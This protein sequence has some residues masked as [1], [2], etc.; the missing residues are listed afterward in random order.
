M[1]S[2]DE[3]AAVRSIGVILIQMFVSVTIET[4]VLGMCI[5]SSSAENKPQRHCSR[6]FYARFQ[7]KPVAHV[8]YSLILIF[9]GS[10]KALCCYRHRSPRTK[11]S[12]AICAAVLVMFV[13]SVVLWIIDIHNTV[14]QIKLT[15]LSSPADTWVDRSSAATNDILRWASI[16]DVLYSYMVRYLTSHIANNENII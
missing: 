16:E 6:I 1:S 4:F 15:L 12:L 2:A 13:L 5:F 8:G 3:V 11:I 14:T 7:G 9:K 10:F